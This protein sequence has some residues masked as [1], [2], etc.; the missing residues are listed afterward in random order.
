[1]SFFDDVE[2]VPEPPEEQA[3]IQQEWMG[4]PDDMI[5][6]VVGLELRVGRSEKAAVYLTALVAYPTGMSLTAEVVTKRVVDPQVFAMLHPRRHR[7]SDGEPDPQLL[8]IGLSF[9][10]QRKA[11]NLGGRPLGAFGPNADAPNPQSDLLLIPGG[12]SGGAHYSRQDYW[13]WPL[14]PPGPVTF[15]C[16]WPALSIGESSAELDGA[17][18]RTAAE[19]ARAVWDA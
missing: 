17:L 14:P 3:W 1:M 16:E 5:G 7:T 19:R 12:G 13:V 4:P 15:V 9:A 8:R 11:T 10:D 18:I 2:R 6:G